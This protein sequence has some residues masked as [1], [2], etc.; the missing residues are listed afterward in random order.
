M[1]WLIYCWHDRLF[2]DHPSYLP[3][4]DELVRQS[5]ETGHQINMERM[6]FVSGR[7]LWDQM[8]EKIFELMNNCG[9]SLSDRCAFVVSRSLLPGKAFLVEDNHIS[10]HVSDYPKGTF[11]CIGLMYL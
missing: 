9:L 10:D 2:D 3:E 11:P 7:R 4:I 6:D 8:V 1:I 5:E